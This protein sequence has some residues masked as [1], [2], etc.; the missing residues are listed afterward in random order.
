MQSDS[1]DLELMRRLGEQRLHDGVHLCA[2]WRPLR[3]ITGP[4]IF[5]AS[6]A[7]TATVCVPGILLPKPPPVYS[8]MSTICSGLM[9]THRATDS[10][11][12]ITLCVEQ[13]R[14]SFP[15]CQYAIAVRV[16]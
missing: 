9:P 7:G 15:F 14:Y 13:C 5:F 1:I 16:S 4:P 3:I 12:R 2:T 10:T 8:L 6:N 11:V